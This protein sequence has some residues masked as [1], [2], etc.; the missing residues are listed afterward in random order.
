[1]TEVEMVGWHHGFNGPEFEQ[2]PGDGKGQRSLACCHPWGLKQLDTSE[3]LT[4][5]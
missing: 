2:A 1:M 5:L 3:G 4:T